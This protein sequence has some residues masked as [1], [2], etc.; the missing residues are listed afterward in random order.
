MDNKVVEMKLPGLVTRMAG[1]E[2]EDYVSMPIDEDSQVQFGLPN[3]EEEFT[4]SVWADILKPTTAQP[5]A[6]YASDYYADQPAVT[7]NAFETGKVIYIGTFGD[8]SYYTEIAKW[9][10]EL[11]GIQPL[12][13]NVPAGVEVAERWQREQ[14][15]LFLLNHNSKSREIQLDDVYLDLSSGKHL[16]GNITIAPFEVLILTG[17]EESVK[18]VTANRS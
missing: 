3:L 1:V 15:L 13:P 4:A 8:A 6:R 12:L 11:A 10:L 18:C 17:G 16:T 5:I 9:I 2:I 14:R 7:L